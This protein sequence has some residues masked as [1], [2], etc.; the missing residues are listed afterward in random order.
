MAKK[1]VKKA[2]K[3][4][5]KKVL[6]ENINNEICKTSIRLDIIIITILNTIKISLIELVLPFENENKGN[7]ENW[8]FPIIKNDNKII[9]GRIILNVKKLIS[10]GFEL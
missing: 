6:G 7:F 9:N 2:A 8:I 5:V 1:K 4:V 3:K 10:A